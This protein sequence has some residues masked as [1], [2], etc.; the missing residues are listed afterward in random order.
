[1]REVGEQ[2]GL[3]LQARTEARQE[4]LKLVGSMNS[5]VGTKA[6]EQM[7]LKM[8]IHFPDVFSDLCLYR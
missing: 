8:K 1:V 7:L 4:A 6:A 2:V 3:S 5:S